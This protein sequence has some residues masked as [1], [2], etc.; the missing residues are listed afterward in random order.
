MMQQAYLTSV[1]WLLP[2][3]PATGVSQFSPA[4]G[5]RQCIW[6]AQKQNL[7]QVT[8]VFKNHTSE[9]PCPL[10]STSKF[11]GE[12]KLQHMHNWAPARFHLPA[13]AWS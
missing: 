11:H 5:I 4:Q 8:P 10:T 9:L 1:H 7:V 12:V 13:E 6:H 2:P 3:V